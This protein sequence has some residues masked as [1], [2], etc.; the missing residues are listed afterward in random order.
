MQTTDNIHVEE[1]RHLTAD[2]PLGRMSCWFR[3][4]ARENFPFVVLCSK[5]GNRGVSICNAH[6]FYREQLNRILANKRVRDYGVISRNNVATI[7]SFWKSTLLS[8]I[9]ILTRM[10]VKSHVYSR[11][12]RNSL[13]FEHWPADRTRSNREEY[14][15]VRLDDEMSPKFSE[16]T[17]EEISITTGYTQNEIL[18]SF[19]QTDHSDV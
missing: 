8:L 3:I 11:F 18:F 10:F 13:W 12:D 4:L 6:E 1:F 14:W 15:V 9:D 7:D 16:T 19:Q 5:R 17:L 2:Q